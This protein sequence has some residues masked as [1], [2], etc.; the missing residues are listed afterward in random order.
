MTRKEKALN[1]RKVTQTELNSISDEDAVTMLNMFP[2]WSSKSVDYYTG[3][4][5]V[6]SDILYKVLQS[7]TSQAT[8]TSDVAPS[9]FEVV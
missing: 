4:R 2:T 8:W 6:Y 5:V 3:D 7:H 1:F 9:L